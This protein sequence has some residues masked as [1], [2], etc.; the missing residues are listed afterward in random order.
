[1][2]NNC[3][4]SNTFQDSF[5]ELARILRHTPK[6]K[7]SSDK[8]KQ[9]INMRRY[10][11]ALSQNNSGI[12]YVTQHSTQT[13]QWKK[14]K[15]KSAFTRDYLSRTQATIITINVHDDANTGRI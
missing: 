12:F 8:T 7:N 2:N 13:V 14:A 1:M 6:T 3:S 5:N 10:V 9:L 15:S 4:A 11:H